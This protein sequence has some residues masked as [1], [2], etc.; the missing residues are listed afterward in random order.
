MKTPKANNIDY[1]KDV[2][3][4]IEPMMQAG[5]GPAVQFIKAQADIIRNDGNL[6]QDMVAKIKKQHSAIDKLAGLVS[7]KYCV[8]DN[9]CRIERQSDGCCGVFAYDKKAC[10]EKLIEWAISDKE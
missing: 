3:H 5:F 4:L 6:I 1:G 8:L 2:A 10:K 9:E 7:C